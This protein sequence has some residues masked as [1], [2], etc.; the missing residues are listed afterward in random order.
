MNDPNSEASKRVEEF[1]LAEARGF[2]FDERE[3][4]KDLQGEGEILPGVMTSEP[5]HLRGLAQPI[6]ARRG[7]LVQGGFRVVGR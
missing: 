4:G 2:V 5:F 7:D 6:V 1:Q 3:K